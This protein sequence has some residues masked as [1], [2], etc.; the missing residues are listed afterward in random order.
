VKGD[1]FGWVR[2]TLKD[3]IKMDVKEVMCEVID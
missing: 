1:S 2:F 3:N